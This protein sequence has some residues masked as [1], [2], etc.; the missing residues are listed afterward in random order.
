M[1]PFDVTLIEFLTSYRLERVP[2]HDNMTGRTVDSWMLTLNGDVVSVRRDAD[3]IL[4][5]LQEM[6]IG[7][8]RETDTDR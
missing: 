7:N 8:R 6:I 2:L 3:R 5:D 1:S 4:N